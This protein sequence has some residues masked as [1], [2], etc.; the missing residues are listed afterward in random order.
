M[1]VDNSRPT[2]RARRN[3]KRTISASEMTARLIERVKESNM[4]V[5]P[6]A[7]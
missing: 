7:A 1:Q 2:G 5:P 4:K 3:A 6:R